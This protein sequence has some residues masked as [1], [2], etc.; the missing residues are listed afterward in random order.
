MTLINEVWLGE[1]IRRT[2]GEHGAHVDVY[3]EVLK[4]IE[5]LEGAL[6][7]AG[8]RDHMVEAILRGGYDPAGQVLPGPPSEPGA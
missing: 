7:A 8:V 3:G 1:E 6:A 2:W 4:A 5:R